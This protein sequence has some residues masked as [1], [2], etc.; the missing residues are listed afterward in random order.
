MNPLLLPR[1]GALPSG[2]AAILKS[3]TASYFLLRRGLAA[4]AFLFPVLLWLGAGYA[5]PQGSISAYYHYREV[6]WGYSPY[7]AGAM[8]NLFV[9]VL[10]AIG[11]FLFF[12]RG[13]S[14]LEDRAL[15][16]AGVAAILVSL[17]PMDWP[18]GNDL[19]R[20]STATVHYASAAT[21]FLATAFVCIFLSGETLEFMKSEEQ[22]RRYRRVYRLLGILMVASPLA[23][24]LIHLA[25]G[26]TGD[27]LVMLFVEVA[28]IYVFAAYW[29]VKSRE[30][31]ILELQS[32]RDPASPGL[33]PPATPG[34]V[35]RAAGG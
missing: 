26:A 6:A 16:V 25:F 3:V 13:Y 7:G 8:R 21:F 27:S 29:A 4:L 34:A 33:S 9:G 15:N 2:E 35:L 32:K 10:W 19:V 14:R 28:G 22:K 17:F 30:I 23:V 12:Y 1:P 18:P 24:L 20:S 11:S 5:H 31:G